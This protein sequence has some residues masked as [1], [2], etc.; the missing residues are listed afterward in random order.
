MNFEGKLVGTDL[1]VA[2]VVSRFNDFYYELLDG[3][4][5]TLVRHGVEDSNIDVACTWCI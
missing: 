1:K 2:I 4:K 5:D 3:A